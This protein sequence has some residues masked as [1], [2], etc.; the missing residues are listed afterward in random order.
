M[1]EIQVSSL[2]F[3]FC[4]YILCFHICFNFFLAQKPVSWAALASKGAGGAQSFP[5][6]SNHVNKPPP[7][8]EPVKVETVP[9]QPPQQQRAPRYFSKILFIEF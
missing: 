9:T 1:C 7:V 6:P 4:P 3:L 8:R 2:Y 5:T